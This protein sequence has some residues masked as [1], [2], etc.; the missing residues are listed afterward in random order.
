MMTKVREARTGN[1]KQGKQIKAEK[2]IPS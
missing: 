1:P 2:F